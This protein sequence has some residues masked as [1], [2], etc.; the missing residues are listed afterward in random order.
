[1]YRSLSLR[2]CRKVNGTCGPGWRSKTRSNG[3]I[4]GFASRYLR[5]GL[6][7]PYPGCGKWIHHFI[8]DVTRRTVHDWQGAFFSIRLPAHILAKWGISVGLTYSAKDLPV[9]SGC[10]PPFRL[11]SRPNLRPSSSSF[12][13]SF[14]NSFTANFW[15]YVFS[16]LCHARNDY[17]VFKVPVKTMVNCLIYLRDRHDAFFSFAV[18]PFRDSDLPQMRTMSLRQFCTASSIGQIFARRYS[19]VTRRPALSW[20][21]LMVF[22]KLPSSRIG[23]ESTH[24]RVMAVPNLLTR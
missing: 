21:L 16:A 24:R 3:V 20:G 8:R 10:W 1:M 9:T 2:D 18:F 12:P 22:L 23:N 4:G 13:A 15:D 6:C 7:N 5:C 17:N 14:S 19:R 11:K